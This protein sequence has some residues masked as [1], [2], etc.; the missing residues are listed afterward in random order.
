MAKTANTP[1]TT[2][3][4]W[5]PRIPISLSRSSDVS[6]ASDGAMIAMRTCARIEVMMTA[7]T[8]RIIFAPVT[9]STASGASSPPKITP[10]VVAKYQP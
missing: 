4:R 3:P 7:T 1:S 8:V 6:S 10:A 5:S 9:A 2:P